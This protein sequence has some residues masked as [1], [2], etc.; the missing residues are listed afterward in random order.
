MQ[1]SLAASPGLWHEASPPETPW[2]LRGAVAKPPRRGQSV[3]A[4]QQEQD[5]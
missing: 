2:E 3:A 1:G 5:F 4:E